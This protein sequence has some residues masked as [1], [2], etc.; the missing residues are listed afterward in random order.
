[1]TDKQTEALKMALEA[2]ELIDA[3]LNNET[4]DLW[5]QKTDAAIT[6]IREALA[7]QP[8]QQHPD[9]QA[10]DRFAAAMKDKLAKAREKGR[11]GWET[12]S[13]ED[14]SRMLREHVEKGDPRDVANFCMM[15]WNLDTGIAA[16]QQE[17]TLQEQ[18]DDALQSLDFYRRR[19]QALQQWQSKMRD[20]ERTIVCDIIANGCALEPAGDRYKQP[21]QQKIG[22][23]GEKRGACGLPCEPCE[24]K[25]DPDYVQQ[26][27]QQPID[28]DALGIPHGTAFQPAQQQ[29]AERVAPVAWM[30]GYRNI[31]SLEEKAAGCED[32]VIPLVP[33][34]LQHWSDCAVHNE[35]AY[36]AGKCDCGGYTSPQPSQRSGKP[37]TPREIELLDG[38]IEVQ[39]DHALRCDSI[40]N[41]TMAEKQKAW[42]M[43]RVELLR[44]LK[45]AHGIKGEQK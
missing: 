35:P 29:S 26:P 16:Q 44:K 8:A 11:G 3:P 31:Y 21:A 40:G 9:D 39:L 10:V 34:T 23:C 27:A 14:L 19:V 30:D 32:A 18:L 37:L 6:A 15:L 4:I 45:A 28:L 7:E 25:T 33:A 36:P 20:P 24:G 12:C 43:E 1:M 41:R 22:V 5:E 17:P 2:L 38:M 42:D 13:P